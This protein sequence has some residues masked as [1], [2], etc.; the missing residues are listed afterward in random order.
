MSTESN[1]QRITLVAVG[2]IQQSA[3]PK[4][5]PLTAPAR[6]DAGNLPPHLSPHRQA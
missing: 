5:C 4:K 6:L 2:F 1:D 3:P